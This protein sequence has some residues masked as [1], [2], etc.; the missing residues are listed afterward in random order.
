[1]RER[2]AFHDHELDEF[3]AQL[4][5]VPG[6]LREAAVVSTCNRTELFAVPAD[7]TAP[8]PDDR[9]LIRL[10]TRDRADPDVLSVQTRR[11]SEA[12][13][14]LCRVAAGLDSM[15][16]G[17]SEVLGQVARAHQRASASGASGPVLNAAFTVAVRAGRRARAETGIGRH[18]ASVSSEAVR[19]VRELEPRLAERTVLIVGTGTVSRLAGESAR[20]SGAGRV[21]VV[22]RTTEHAQVLA[23]SIGGEAR[24]WHQLA[25]SLIAADVV[26]S[27]TG[28]PHAVLTAEL[29]RAAA[30]VAP[31][32]RLVVDV[33]VPRDVEADAGSLEGVQLFDID[34]IQARV[35]AN[36]AARARAVPD[37]ER[38]VEQEVARFEAW[39]R[40]ES[41]RPVLAALH[42]KGEALRRRELE[43]TLRRL[44]DG[45]PAMRD[46]LERL[47]AALVHGLLDRPSRC[48]REEAD[49]DRAAG[50]ADATRELF[51]LDDAASDRVVVDVTGPAG[52]A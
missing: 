29:F 16:L 10:L 11:A 36:H 40:G 38:I 32:R 50:F 24:P 17:E 25:A 23:E 14:H 8:E 30:Q 52:E 37:A 41:L 39:R 6:P 49:P 7:S 3:Y 1:M 26:I 19:L 13:R 34:A 18:A 5:A 42:A 21:I 28:A 45:N 20:A 9:R 15:I 31:R 46:E 22:G 51:G 35:D 44:G 43:R 27:S 48:L 33:S 2:L 47:S 4:R 12:V